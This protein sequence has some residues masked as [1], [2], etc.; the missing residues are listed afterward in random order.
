[1]PHA[2]EF[3]KNM[4]EKIEDVSLVL[5][6]PLFFAFTGLR[7]QIG[8]LNEGHLWVVCLAV[9]AVA[10]IGKFGGTSL[11]AR[12]GQP[13]R[14]QPAGFVPAK[15]LLHHWRLT[16]AEQVYPALTKCAWNNRGCRN[17]LHCLHPAHVLF[18]AAH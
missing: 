13:S 11:A 4:V 12:R 7:T 1:M 17:Y 5:L 6:L 14:Q 10:V 18:V 9:I 15:R 2:T 16:Q 3:K 8:L